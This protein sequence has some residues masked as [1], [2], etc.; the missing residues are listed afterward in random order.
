MSGLLILLAIVTVINFGRSKDSETEHEFTANNNELLM[1]NIRCVPK[2]VRSYEKVKDVYGGK[3]ILF[4]RYV[5]NACSSCLNGYLTEILALQEEIGKKHIWIFP[6]YPDDR[7]SRIQLSNELAKYNYRNIPCDS[8]LIPIY[9]GEEKSYFAW[10]NNEREIEMV[11]IPDKNKFQDT[12]N[13]LL[14][15]KQ[16]IQRNGRGE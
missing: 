14:E 12:R 16:I 5:N 13:Y 7:S 2:I 11:F 8:L 9:E 1:T 10:I 4:F 3:N 6:A 15:M